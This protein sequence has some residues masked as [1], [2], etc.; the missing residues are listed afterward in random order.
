MLPS[1]PSAPRPRS[2]SSSISGKQVM[3]NHKLGSRLV[4]AL[5]LLSLGAGGCMMQIEAEVPEV[6][7]TQHD[8]RFEGVSVAGN[9]L[10]DVSLSK[11]FSQ[12]HKR[13]DLPAGP[14]TEVKAMGVTL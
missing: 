3:R 6:E 10:G 14:D 8:L 9:A 2:V 1:K 12:K 5:A 13:L 7:I 11:S 4:G